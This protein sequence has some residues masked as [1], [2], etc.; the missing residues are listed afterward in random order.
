M[1][2]YV[3]LTQRA[4]WPALLARAESLV[5]S[6]MDGRTARLTL[7]KEFSVA[8][9]L[10]TNAIARGDI[11]AIPSDEPARALA[12]RNGQTLYMGEPCE[13]CGDRERWV[14]DGECAECNR[15]YK[16]ELDARKHSRL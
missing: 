6:G 9:G 14:C 3:P 15:A 2:R 1:T 10:L 8:R 12:G 7:A 16:R 5:S 4:Y 11:P 13:K